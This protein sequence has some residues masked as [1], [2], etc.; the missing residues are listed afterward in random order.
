[1]ATPGRQ[2]GGPGF[3][4]VESALATI[5]RYEMVKEG[6]TVV[7]AVSGGPDS[8]C[9]LDV[10]WR[11]ASR[12]DITLAVA[13][14]DHGLS[15][16]SGAI[17]A[18]VARQGATDGFDVHTVRAPDLTGPN[19]HARAR[20]FRYG[21]LEIVASETNADRIATGHT[22]DDRVETTLARLV[23]GAGT[24]S[25]AGVPPVE[26]NRIRPLIAVRRAETRRYCEEVGLAF[27]ADPA[28]DDER[29]ER[30]V[31]RS[32]VLAPIEDHWGE[33]AVRAMAR[34]AELLREDA[35]ALDGLAQRLYSELAQVSSEGTSFDRESFSGIPRA[36]KH[37]LLDR[38][39]GRVRDR[40]GGIEAA[41]DG[42]E[43]SEGREL[44][45]SVAEGIEIVVRK[46]RVLVTGAERTD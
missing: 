41:L 15:D 2:L 44:R 8:T 1:M 34:S 24:S 38:A 12:L 29:F 6:D 14:V 40:S 37:R 27:D 11:L 19:L 26:G 31:I 9:T 30:T 33:G 22:L 25:L 18:R 7:V 21:F 17:A 23:H 42:L 4:I 20:E 43:T 28:N 39:V 32:R 46:D 10:L 36:L 16:E 35:I 45:Y 13:H 5:R 3:E